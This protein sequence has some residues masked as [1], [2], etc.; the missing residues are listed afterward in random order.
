MPFEM[1]ST[2]SIHAPREGGD[3][4]MATISGYLT[5]FNPRPPRGGRLGTTIAL[6]VRKHPISIHAPREGATPRPRRMVLFLIFQSTPPARGAT[7]QKVEPDRKEKFQ[8]TPPARGAT[9]VLGWLWRDFDISIHAPCEGGDVCNGRCDSGSRHFNPRPLRG[10]RPLRAAYFIYYLEFQSTPPARGAT[11]PRQ[12]TNQRTGHFNPRPLRGGRRSTGP[13][14]SVPRDISIH[15]P[16]EG[17]D[18]PGGFGR[19][20]ISHFNPRPLRG[21]RR[22]PEESER[23]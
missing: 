18:R 19:P 10:G 7:P 3:S 9:L 11:F 15:A 14:E 5:D 16:C 17:G 6:S 21:G 12:H 20:V 2:I 4:E 8:S 1:D 22:Y 23:R 13:L